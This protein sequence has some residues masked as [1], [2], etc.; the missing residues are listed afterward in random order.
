MYLEATRKTAPKSLNDA[1]RKKDWL[2]VKR[3]AELVQDS[4]EESEPEWQ[5]AAEHIASAVDVAN[6]DIEKILARPSAKRIREAMEEWSI[7]EEPQQRLETNFS[8]I[9]CRR[10]GKS[11]RW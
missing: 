3:F 6:K 9:G 10:L 1:A 7:F 4:F 2:N 11:P 8:S 5:A